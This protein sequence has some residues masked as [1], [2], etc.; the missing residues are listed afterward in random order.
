MPFSFAEVESR[1]K[2]H[3][4][5]AGKRVFDLVVSIGLL[6]CLAPVIAATALAVAFSSGRPVIFSQLRLT[7]GG[8]VFTMYK[9]RSMR[10][11]AEAGTGAVWAQINDPRVTRIG[12]F[13]R[14]TRLDELPQLINVIQGDMS[15]IGPRPERP[16][17]AEELA[18]ELPSFHRR[19]EV[20][21]GLTGLAQVNKGYASCIDSYRRKLALDLLYIKKRSFLLDLYI[22]FRTVL[23]ILTGSG[24]R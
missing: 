13:L 8:R 2:A 17:I 22:S 19:L 1:Y 18:K 4:Y 3:Q 10:Q 21:A 20:K 24:A 11:D 23:V 6:L 15:M 9:F 16:E 5:D 12:H 14:V 7:K